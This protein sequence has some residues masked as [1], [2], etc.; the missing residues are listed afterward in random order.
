[1]MR[2]TR[3][4]LTVTPDLSSDAF[5][6]REPYRPLLAAWAATTAGAAGS[7]AAGRSGRKRMEQY[8]DLH[9]E[10]AVLALGL[11][12]PVPLGRAAVRGEPVASIDLTHRS[13]A[14]LP[15][16]Y[17]SMISHLGFPAS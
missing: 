5:I 15:R 12:D 4:R 3:R 9:P 2:Q 17:S 10:P 16:S 1:M 11:Q 7:G 14:L 8:V 13:T 6:L